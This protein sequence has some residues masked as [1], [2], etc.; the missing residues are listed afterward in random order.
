MAQS[1]R[2]GTAIPSSTG[3][4]VQPITALVDG[5]PPELQ[6]RV[7]AKVTAAWAPFVSPAAGSVSTTRPAG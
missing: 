2:D 6:E 1:L 4:D 7:W 3:H 5:Q